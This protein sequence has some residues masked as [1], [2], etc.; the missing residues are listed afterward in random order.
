[1]EPR[2]PA[3]YGGDERYSAGPQDTT[4]LAE[5]PLPVGSVGQVIHR[6]EQEDGV[7]APVR[8]V[9]LAGVAHLRVD[10]HSGGLRSAQRLL[11]VDCDHVAQ[12]HLA[13]HRRQPQGVAARSAADVSHSGRHRREMPENQLPGPLEL[14]RAQPG[15]EPALLLAEGVVRHQRPL[16]ARVDPLHRFVGPPV[17]R[18]QAPLGQRG[19]GPAWAGLCARADQARFA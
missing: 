12:Q 9:E 5:A 8:Q 10:H 18:R 6:A 4:G 1:V 16:L 14:D 11:D 7:D 13:A 2:A 3:R 17:R 15:A 19:W